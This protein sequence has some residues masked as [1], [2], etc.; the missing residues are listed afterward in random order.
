MVRFGAGTSWEAW[1]AIDRR[2]LPYCEELHILC[3]EGYELSKGVEAEYYIAL[4]Y[5]I[6]VK[7]VIP[8]VH[9]DKMGFLQLEQSEDLEQL[10]LLCRDAH[11]EA[12]NEIKK[13]HLEALDNGN[14]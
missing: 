7:F 10:Y 12:L 2:I 4:D 6:P 8:F 11:S 13:E 3:V 5:Q 9:N 1:E 14:E